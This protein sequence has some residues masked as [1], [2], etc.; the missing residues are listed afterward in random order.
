MKEFVKL[1]WKEA[2]NYTTK[3]HLIVWYF[4]ISLVLMWGICDD[5]SILVELLIVFNFGNAARLIR[6]VDLPNNE[7][8]DL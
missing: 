2:S 4:F 6:N 7:Y 1:I 3:Q 5:T 8:E